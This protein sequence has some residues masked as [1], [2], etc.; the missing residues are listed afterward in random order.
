MTP[1]PI[2]MIREGTEETNPANNSDTEPTDVLLFACSIG[3]PTDREH[4][5]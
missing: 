5:P 3:G 2:E 1:V 4:G